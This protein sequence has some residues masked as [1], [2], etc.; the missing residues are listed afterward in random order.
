MKKT[1]LVNAKIVNEGISFVSDVLIHHGRIEKIA[2]HI[3]TSN[4]D[5]IDLNGNYLIPGM[6]D[7]QVHFRDPGLTYTCLLYT[8]DAADD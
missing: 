8:S 2:A 3:T 6:I 7:D 4:A 1:L 5:I